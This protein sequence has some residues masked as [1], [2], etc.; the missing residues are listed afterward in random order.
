MLSW[1]ESGDLDPK[2]SAFMDRIAGEVAGFILG[3]MMRPVTA[4]C[5]E[6]NQRT[7]V[8]R[9]L[10]GRRSCPRCG[11]KLFPISH[12]PASIGVRGRAEVLPTGFASAQIGF[13]CGV[14]R[15]FFPGERI[16]CPVCGRR[17]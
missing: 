6:C 17:N 1:G 14:T 15:G 7:E 16:E 13:T 12:L 8:P 11:G 4:L 2:L 3:R 9:P 10:P 5:L